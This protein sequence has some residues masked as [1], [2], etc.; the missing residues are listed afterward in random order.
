MV[1]TEI[2][3]LQLLQLRQVEGEFATEF[4]AGK[5]EL[6]EVGQVGD[7]FRDSAGNSGSHQN[8]PPQAG[9]VSDDAAERADQRW[10]FDEDELF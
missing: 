7:F 1:V 3:N 5:C 8:K 4:V 10:V 6:F 9:K 2:E